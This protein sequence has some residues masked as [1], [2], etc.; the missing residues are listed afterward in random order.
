MTERP[1]SGIVL[2]S[3]AAD[4]LRSSVLQGIC[5]GSYLCLSLPSN[6]EYYLCTVSLD[7]CSEKASDCYISGFC[8]TFV[9]LPHS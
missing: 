1:S 9:I 7:F 4:I 5:V 2:L 8:F 3:F 6:V